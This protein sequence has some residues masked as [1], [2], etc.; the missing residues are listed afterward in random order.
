MALKEQSTFVLATQSITGFIIN[1]FPIQCT[2]FF[3][4]APARLLASTIVPILYDTCQD[5]FDLL[6]TS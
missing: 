4:F 6:T 1:V 5:R 2:T 3:T